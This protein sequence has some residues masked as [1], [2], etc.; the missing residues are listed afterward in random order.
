MDNL[1]SIQRVKDS[2]VAHLD[3]CFTHKT[4]K[5]MLMKL[6]RL[7]KEKGVIQKLRLQ[8]EAGGSL[9]VNFTKQILYI[10]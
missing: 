9:I 5:R 1:D 2:V 10:L 3:L 7:D 8:K 6:C 4:R